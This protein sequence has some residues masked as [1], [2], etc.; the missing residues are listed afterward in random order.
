MKTSRRFVKLRPSLAHKIIVPFVSILLLMLGGGTIGFGRWM[1]NS[2]EER[3][4]KGLDNLSASI[5]SDFAQEQERVLHWARTVASNEVVVNGVG[6]QD[7]SSLRQV[8]LPIKAANALDLITVVDMQGRIVLELR[9][10]RL[11]D[12]QIDNR[13]ALLPAVSGM[14][15]AGV[16][17]ADDDPKIV[18]AGE[19]PLKSPDGIV[20]GVLVGRM[21]DSDFL[22]NSLPG[23]GAIQVM[24]V[25]GGRTYASTADPEAV[26]E[27]ES[28]KEEERRIRMTIGGQPFIGTS[29]PLITYGQ[30]TGVSILVLSN[31]GDLVEM[32]RALWMRLAA[33]LLAGALVVL[34]IGFV[35]SWSITAPVVELSKVAERLSQGDMTARA[36]TN[37][38]DEVGA[39]GVAFNTMVEA[40]DESGRKVS[41]AYAKL[42]ESHHALISAHEQLR[43]LLEGSTRLTDTL[44]LGPLLDTVG[45]VLLA[46][47]NADSVRLLEVDGQGDRASGQGLF[48]RRNGDH[49]P[50]PVALGAWIE[51]DNLNGDGLNNVIFDTIAAKAPLFYDGI[52]PLEPMQTA[53]IFDVSLEAVETMGRLAVI[54]LVSED[55]V[56][57]VAVLAKSG[58][59]GFSPDQQSVMKA[60]A[61]TAA[62]AVRNARLFAEVERLSVM[63]TLTQVKNHRA[64]RENLD[65]EIDRAQRHNYA[66]SVAMIDV[67]NFKLLNDT[68]GHLTG[69]KVLQ[70]LAQVFAANCRVAD[71]VGRYG[72]DEF[73][74]VLPYTDAEQAAILCQRM[75]ERL[76]DQ[77]SFVVENQ[78]LPVSLSIGIASYP[79][80]ALHPEELLEKADAAM[81][82]AKWSGGGAIIRA[83]DNVA[84]ELSQD[85]PWN[86]LEGLITAVDNKD[87]Y[88]RRHSETVASYSLALARELGFTEE[89]SSQLEVAALFHDVGKLC[90][91][92]RILRKPGPLTADERRILEQHPAFGALLVNPVSLPEPVLDAIRY[93]HERYDGLG[94]PEGLK[95]AGIPLTARILAVADAFSAMIAD[96][97]YRKALP[98]AEAV[99]QIRD[100]SGAQ[101]DPVVAN[102]LIRILTAE[103]SPSH[104]R[105]DV[106]RP[107]GYLA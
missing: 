32:Q 78:H 77:R 89:S 28:L 43:S 58:N 21:V 36:R 53:A 76:A 103:N 54:P 37:I 87:H 46:L 97:P 104:Q 84:R 86:V 67:D 7:V 90:V 24:V 23:E 33:Y 22:R 27:H 92:D 75:L 26:M 100:H 52:E 48:Y 51:E 41:A 3:T 10:A 64:I 74:L 20:G 81:Y 1:T 14:F 19:A 96:R 55:Q 79:A 9:S 80:N 63:D 11:E 94:Y 82:Q 98:I 91:P 38:N 45:H 5:G 25:G 66:V 106:A 42:E 13:Q 95:G 65:A 12:T 34:L 44:Q 73:L 47:S 30:E 57:A 4:W 31:V 71:A 101:F 61:N 59:H 35:V 15:L 29:F 105:E 83:G 56:L 99:E 93:H 40:L 18:L 85:S 50:L 2:M 60:F 62:L 102:S 17:K 68:L 6:R 8:L 16:I 70:Q 49:Q 69:D 107:V 39:L 88:T 72:G